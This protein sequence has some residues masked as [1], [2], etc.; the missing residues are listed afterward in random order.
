M[1]D[2]RPFLSKD[3]YDSTNA[4]RFEALGRRNYETA[5]ALS[6]SPTTGRGRGSPMPYPY[7]M[8]QAPEGSELPLSDP[9]TPG[10]KASAL[11]WMAFAGPGPLIYFIG[12]SCGES[13][14]DPVLADASVCTRFSRYPPGHECS[15]VGD[16]H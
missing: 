1:K 3:R 11:S 12:G 4:T 14:V 10:R 7:S 15:L 13:V 8:G 6:E 2:C 9:W 16:R 5:R